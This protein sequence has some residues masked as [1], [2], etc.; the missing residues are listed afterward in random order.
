MSFLGSGLGGAISSK[1]NL[2]SP[3]AIGAS[4]LTLLGCGLLSSIKGGTNIDKA[5]YGYEF[6]F[7]LGCG[8]ILSSMT[9]MVNLVS[10]T[11]DNGMFTNHTHYD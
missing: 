6:I 5:V 3:T 2:T 7:G 9:M 4:C 10:S 1:R 8:L 11:E